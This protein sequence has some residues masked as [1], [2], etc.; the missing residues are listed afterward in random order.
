MDNIPFQ[1][2]E[3]TFVNKKLQCGCNDK[4]FT[5]TKYNRIYGRLEML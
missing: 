3:F 1:I 4:C 5:F 2:E